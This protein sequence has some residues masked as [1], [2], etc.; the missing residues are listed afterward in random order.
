MRVVEAERLRQLLE[1]ERAANAEINKSE[2]KQRLREIRVFKRLARLTSAV[3]PPAKPAA[4]K[5]RPE[6]Q[7]RGPVV[8]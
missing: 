8:L 4:A 7:L 1:E 2:M 5:P 6:P 3:T